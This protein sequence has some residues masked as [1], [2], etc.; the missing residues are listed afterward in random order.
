MN[1]ISLHNYTHFSLLYSLISPKD[2][3]NRAKELGQD[4]VAITDLCTLAGAWDCLKYSKQTGVKLIIG[5]ELNFINSVSNKS[6]DF[7]NIV[8]LAKNAVGY[9]NLLT[10]SKLGFDNADTSGKKIYPL[11][12][13]N[14]LE[15][16][17]EGLICLT[18]GG[19]GIIS[20]LIMKRDY[21]EAKRQILKLKEIFK[22]NLALEVQANTLVKRGNNVSD[23][24]DQRTINFQ[25]IKLAKEFGIKLVATSNS[26]YLNKEDADKHDVLL[27]IGSHQPKSSNFRMKYDPQNADFY[28]KSGEEVFN[29]FNRNFADI[30]QEMCDNTKYFSDMCEQADWIDPKYSNPSG[31]ELP[32]FPVKDQPDY[33]HFLK[34]VDSRPEL[35]GF[36]DDKNY[37]RYKCETSDLY[38]SL[39]ADKKETYTKRLEEELDV[40]DYCGVTSYMLI[41]ADYVNWAKNNNVPTGPGRGSA[42][43]SY[44][45][46]LLG[47]HLA[48]PIKYGLVFERFHN[49][50]KKATSDIDCDFSRDNRYLVEQY[51]VN[52]YGQD[53]VAHVSNLIGITPKVY[54]RDIARA[55]EFGGS[56]ESAV[57]IGN[58]LS[59]VIPKDAHTID[60][61]VK[62]APIYGE[63]VQRYPE[64]NTYKSIASKFRS[65]GTHAAG[66][67][68]SKRPLVGL[69]PLR[70]DKDGSVALEYE[71]NTAE[72]NGLI[73]MDILGLSTLDIIENT[74]RLIK[75]AGKEVPKIDYET[76]DKAT[77][78]LISSGDTFKVFQFG[79]SA[80]TIDL[81]KKI[82]PKSID[83]LAIITTIARP[84][85]R[86][87]REDFIKTRE[88]KREPSYIHESLKDSLEPTFGFPIYDESLLTLARDVAGWDL[89]EA[90]KLR[91]LTKEKGK[92][93]EKAKKWKEEFI[94]GAVKKGIDEL[95]AEKIWTDIIEPFGLYSFNKSHAVL[96]SMISY[97]TAYLKAH[98]P[99][100]FLMAN[101]IEELQS[102]TPD[103]T[104]NIEKIKNEIKKYKVKILPP[105]INISEMH[106]K[107][108]DNNKLLTGLSALK[109]VSDDAIADIVAKRPFNSFFDFMLKV[110][111]RKVRVDAIRALA[112]AGCLNDFGIDKKLIFYYCQDYRKKLQSWLKKHDPKTEQFNY[113]WPKSDTWSPR[114]LY[115]LE[116]HYLGESISCRIHQV[117]PDFFKN[118]ES[119]PLFKVK[120]MNDKDKVKSVKVQVK[121]FI[122]LK[123]KKE[124]SKYYG[125]IMVKA[126]VNDMYGEQ[127]YI[128]IF[129]D[130]WDEVQKRIKELNKKGKFEA[131]CLLHFGASVNN[132]E[133]ENNLILNSLY[134]FLPPPPL[135][136]DLKG[137]TVSVPREKSVKKAEVNQQDMFDNL[138]EELLEDG[139]I[140]EDENG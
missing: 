52:K 76:Y 15:K 84:A 5:A 54:V 97:H 30:A 2:I 78:D 14:I 29:F 96:Y 94:E 139:L 72:D 138:E 61:L 48:D 17:S 62:S 137:K 74:N 107:L 24:I 100:E 22:E 43:G 129:P 56:R 110:D 102:N 4:A 124:K 31:K 101:L 18:S 105:D 57:K 47:I 89:G 125:R 65:I 46:Y 80:G 63:Y 106:Y 9:R 134:D 136:A 23:N 83:D 77:Y 45:G 40:L 21:D 75:E 87:I 26:L 44:V 91:K 130:K 41:V 82:Q 67:I 7:R 19:S 79:T 20:Q 116:K 35:I 85:S 8:L 127:C 6:E 39:P 53:N 37:I 73:K 113:P 140:S 59:D 122:E 103:A 93:P 12:D 81:C 33:Q 69:V 88:G 86:E 71:K 60:S 128:T 3:F 49:K 120:K 66:S 90:D 108:I 119:T 135:P 64:L 68:I 28:F 126:S 11:I 36:E 133:D 114:D 58:D 118:S 115:S 112:S 92:N 34:W 1:Y 70:K 98:F 109:F 111:S 16:Y 117:Y 99:I 38:T 55:C 132:Y 50:L 104:E 95:T 13:W 42:G 10:I 51:I 32:E 121:E 25:I 27:S 123:I 131:G